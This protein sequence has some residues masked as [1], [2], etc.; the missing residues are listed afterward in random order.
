MKQSRRNVANA[1]SKAERKAQGKPTLSKYERK[2][3]ITEV[4][5]AK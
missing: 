2:T 4:T 1:T 3:R 5:N